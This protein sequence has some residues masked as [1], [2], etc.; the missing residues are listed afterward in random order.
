MGKPLPMAL[1]KRV[2]A[3]VDGGHGH[4]EAARHFRVS[5]RFVNNLMKLSG[6]ERLARAASAG[7]CRRGQAWLACDVCAAAASRSGR[8]DA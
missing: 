6:A 8:V 1:R 3:Y 2:A 4:R 7:R 5:P